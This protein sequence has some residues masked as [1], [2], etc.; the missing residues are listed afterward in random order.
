MDTPA[1]KS[2]CS[3]KRLARFGWPSTN[4]TASSSKSRSSCCAPV[5]M[6]SIWCGASCRSGA[7][8]PGSRIPGSPA[9]S[10]A[11][12]A[13]TPTGSPGMRW[14]MSRACRSLITCAACTT[15]CRWLLITAYDEHGCSS[16]AG[17]RMPRAAPPVFVF[18]VPVRDN[19]QRMHSSIGYQTPEQCERQAEA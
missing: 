9:S 8:S 18:A 7:S 19:R 17:G 12:P 1:S 15:T 16:V 14:P 10:T 13:P 11:A 4:R 6:T 3:L 5:A 2:C